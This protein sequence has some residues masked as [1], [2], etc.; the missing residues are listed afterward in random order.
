VRTETLTGSSG[1][2]VMPA[3]GT[4][5]AVV[6]I[7]HGGKA[8]S[9][10]PSNP[11][12]LSRAR[13]IPF[14]R[15]IHAATR[16]DGVATWRLTYRVRGW[17]GSQESPVRDARWAL[18][19]V[20]RRHGDVPVVLLGHSMGGRTALAV[21]DDP[22][23]RSVIALGPWL[24]NGESVQAARHRRIVIA[25]AARDRWTNPTESRQWAARAEFL[26]D[27]VV[28]IRVLRAGHFMLR[29]ARTWTSIATGFVLEALG[30]LDLS[31]R[32]ASA[33]AARLVAEAAVGQTELSV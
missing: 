5:R 13:M 9:V 17:N 21:C 3:R 22:A 7:L 32:A 19:E 14:A 27:R 12:H 11:R 31:T 23:V 29:R 8:V 16:S 20:R 30:D 6:L 26:A 18:D 28:Y 4:T 25:H 33:P 15:A 1:V 24:P 2:E 10:D